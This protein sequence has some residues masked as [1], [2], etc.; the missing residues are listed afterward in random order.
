[1]QF[2]KVMA[3][4]PVGTPAPLREWFPNVSFANHLTPRRQAAIAATADVYPIAKSSP[5]SRPAFGHEWV[6][7][8]YEW[9]SVKRVVRRT[10][11][12]TPNSLK[13]V[14]KRALGVVQNERDHAT[15]KVVVFEGHPYQADDT[16]LR[17]VAGAIMQGDANQLPDG[18]TWR[19]ADNVDVL[20]PLVKLKGLGA[21][22]FAQVNDA[23]K[24][25]HR[26]KDAVRAAVN[27]Q[28][29]AAA[30]ELS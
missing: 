4:Q 22:M 17:N 11:V 3:G 5:S 9:D 24:H 15:R 2:M 28:E 26:R 23:Y 7:S 21:T 30:L 18:F 10:W 6:P 27:V 1:M 12:E 29:L 19:D 8:G 16:S 25:A 20:M 13:S 14:R